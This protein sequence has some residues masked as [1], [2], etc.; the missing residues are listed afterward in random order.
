MANGEAYNG[1]TYTSEIEN[2]SLKVNTQKQGVSSYAGCLYLPGKE[3]V[4]QRVSVETANSAGDTF[5]VYARLNKPDSSNWKSMTGYYVRYNKNDGNLILFKINSTSNDKALIKCG[6]RKDDSDSKYRIELVATGTTST[7]LTVKMYKF[8]GTAWIVLFQNTYVDTDSPFT[9]G[10]AGIAVGGSENSANNYTYLDNFQYTSTDNVKDSPKYLS[11]SRTVGFKTFGQVVAL[12][13]G[14]EYVF[15]AYSTVDVKDDGRYINEPLWVEYQTGTY[16][17]SNTYQRIVTDRSSIQ[18]TAELTKV[19]CKQNNLEYSE[20]NLSYVTFTA[21]KGDT[22]PY[23]ETYAGNRIRHI[24][25]IRLN[26]SSYLVGNY[27][28]FT[29]YRKDDPYKTNLLV[30]PDF[31]MGFYGWSDACT[32][33]AYTQGEETSDVSTK[34]GYVTL[35]SDKNNYEYYSLFKN[36][37]YEAVEHDA[38]R[39]Q[40][41]DVTDLVF[42]SISENDYYY[43]IDYDKNGSIGSADLAEIK[44][45]LLNRVVLPEPEVFGLDNDSVDDD[46]FS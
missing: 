28:Y 42:A 41:F 10:T 3:T 22:D 8:N 35:L 37:S 13:Q 19:Q 33:W 29:L 43:L 7:V 18:K 4:N 24:V 27:S 14:V 5:Y 9:R 15:A 45:Q 32:Y 31:K 44:I 30:N 38:N 2:G 1:N 21:G 12:E 25:G 17:S 26:Q 23:V 40:D 39:D 6:Y 46:I 36:P 11:H 16:F 34:N 20:Y